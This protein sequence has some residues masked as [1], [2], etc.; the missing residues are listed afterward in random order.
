VDARPAGV[1]DSAA[2]EALKQSDFQADV[3]AK[4]CRSVIDFTSVRR[5]AF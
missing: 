4:D 1:F 2:A 3:K 5:R